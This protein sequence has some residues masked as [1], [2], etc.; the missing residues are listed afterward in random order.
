[1]AKIIDGIIDMSRTMTA[2][3]YA[4]AWKLI[5]AFKAIHNIYVFIMCCNCKLLAQ[6]F[7]GAVYPFSWL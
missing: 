7:D 1:M 5:G 3:L 6:I 2:Y 4:M